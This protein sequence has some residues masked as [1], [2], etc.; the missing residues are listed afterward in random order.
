LRKLP[1]NRSAPP[2]GQ[3][4][5]APSPLMAPQALGARIFRLSQGCEK[6][7]VNLNPESSFSPATCLM[8][9]RDPN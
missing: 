2:G 3:A 6:G 8:S 5:G 9:R 4:G 7:K 1:V